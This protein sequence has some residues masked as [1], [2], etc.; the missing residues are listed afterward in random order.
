MRGFGDCRSMHEV[1]TRVIDLHRLRWQSRLLHC[2]P[3]F[4]GRPF[5]EAVLGLEVV[6]FAGRACQVRNG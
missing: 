5:R 1:K 4:F 3:T 2:V 6:R